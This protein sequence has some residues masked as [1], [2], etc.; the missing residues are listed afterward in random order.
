LIGIK[1]P[2]IYDIVTDNS[3][4]CDLK[5]DD[6]TGLVPHEGFAKG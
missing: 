3:M 5:Y 6:L 2:V 4:A 1:Q